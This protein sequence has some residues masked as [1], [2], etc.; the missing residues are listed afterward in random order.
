[1]GV[2]QREEFYETQPQGS[3]IELPNAPMVYCDAMAA[4]RLAGC[5]FIAAYYVNHIDP[6]SR[7]VERLVNL[8]LKMPVR[9]VVAALP[10]VM[11]LLPQGSAEEVADRMRMYLA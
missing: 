5:D 10:Y 7:E 4:C 2:I 8:R 6:N 9:G 3:F 11:R 1:M